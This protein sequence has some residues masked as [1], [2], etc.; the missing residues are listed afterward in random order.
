M[1]VVPTRYHDQSKISRKFPGFLN[2]RRRKI[3]SRSFVNE[4][5]KIGSF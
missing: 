5:E 3:G 1:K 4:N 2:I